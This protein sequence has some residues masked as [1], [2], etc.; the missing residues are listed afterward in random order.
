LTALLKDEENMPALA[1]HEPVVDEQIWREWVQ[2]GKRG[3]TTS[4]RRFKVTAGI[5]I[6]LLAVASAFFAGK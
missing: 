6:V 3:A 1:N 5:A 2:K 4:A